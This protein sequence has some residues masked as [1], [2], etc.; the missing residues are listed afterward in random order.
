MEPCAL[1]KAVNAAPL[2]VPPELAA[3]RSEPWP[4]SAIVAVAGP[5]GVKSI[6]SVSARTP[7][8]TS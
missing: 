2:G 7:V 5:V 4:S 8:Q 3:P 1:L 6:S